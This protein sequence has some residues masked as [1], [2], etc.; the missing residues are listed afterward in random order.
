MFI[1]TQKKCNYSFLEFV[2]ESMKDGA[3]SASFFRY[4]WTEQ[5]DNQNEKSRYNCYLK[6]SAI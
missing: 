6:G 4:F 5:D 2:K 3:R 1:V